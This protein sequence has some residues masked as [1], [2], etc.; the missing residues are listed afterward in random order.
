MNKEI[1]YQN[2]VLMG[3]VELSSRDGKGCWIIVEPEGAQFE[4]ER[5]FSEYSFISNTAIRMKYGTSL[6][7]LIE[8][9]LMDYT[10]SKAK[11]RIAL[12]L[13]DMGK[14][15]KQEIYSAS[16]KS[17][18]K[19]VEDSFIQKWILTGLV[20]IRKKNPLN[21]QFEEIDVEGFCAILGINTQQYL[22]NASILMEENL[23]N[24]GE[25]EGFDISSGGIYVTSRGIKYLNELLISE[26]P[27]S[28]MSGKL[29]GLEKTGGFEYDIAITFAGENRDIAEALATGL[30]EKNISV[31]YDIF[32]QSELWGKN[33]Y[34]HLSY[35]YGKAAR[36]CI[37][38]L[39]KDYAQKMWT[40]LERQSAQARAFREKTEYILPIRLDETEIPGL[41]ETVGYVTLK[42]N[43]IEHIIE[44]IYRKLVKIS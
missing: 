29:T 15:Y 7:E 3:S 25:P 21:Y 14:E 22:F 8:S 35:I 44:L 42:D 39:S 31:F 38:L 30:K 23:I 43:S 6:S 1:K 13:F 2:A 17:E 16:L 5:L 9:D 4:S 40:S 20:N 41:P 11:A 33:L 24:E 28:V 36:Y 32:E 18:L 37:M 34:D 10:F 26:K 12:A 27:I 19:Q